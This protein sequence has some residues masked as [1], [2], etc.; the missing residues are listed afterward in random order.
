ML[1]HRR[2]HRVP[3]FVL[4]AIVA[5]WG[6]GISSAGSSQQRLS[7]KGFVVAGQPVLFDEVLDPQFSTLQ[8]RSTARSTRAG[9][10]RWAQTQEGRRLVQ[11]FRTGE[12]EVEI[13]EDHEEGS[14]GR[15]PE[16]GIATMLAAADHHK[17]KRY[18]LILNPTLAEQYRGTPE[19]GGITEVDV[20]AATWA[21]EMLH[22]EF[23]AD[24]IAL[25]H[26]ERDDFQERWTRVARQLGL[27]NFAHGIEEITTR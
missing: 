9:F 20:M 24:G 21:G 17:T 22:I 7:G 8:V 2:Q 18:Q 26:H 25:P 16:P 3:L 6:L 15:A 27:P 19:A 10:A 13:I 5:S 11:R 4:T 14:P 23:Y 1:H 12:Y